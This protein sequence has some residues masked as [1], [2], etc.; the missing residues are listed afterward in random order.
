MK[1]PNV[2]QGR[3]EKVT[4]GWIHGVNSVRNPWNLPADQLKWGV[5]VTVRGGIVQTRPG[6]G[7]KLSLP[8]GNLQGGCFFASN[9][10]AK[11]AST[12]VSSGTTSTVSAT[13]YNYDGTTSFEEEL[14]Y[15]LFAVGG[16]VYFSPFP[17]V[18][19]KDWNDYKLTN[20]SLSPDVKEVV[21]CVATQT[22]SLSAGGDVTVT[23]SNR[24]VII[25][26]GVSAPA[27]WDG[28]DKR[29]GQESKIPV[30]YWMSFSGN[31]L[32]VAA[33]NIVFASDIGNPFSWIERTEG[34]GRGDFSFP[35][36]ITAMVDYIG[37]DNDT[38][39]IVFTDRSTYSLSSGI[40]DRS[41]WAST[42]NFQKTLYAT[43]GCVAGK[44][45]A[46][47]AGLMWW[48]S[49]GGLV[50]ANVASGAYVSSQSLYKDVE[51][52]RA[53]RYMPSNVS[54]ICATSFENY[55]LYSIPYLEA[56]PSATMVLDYAAAS[57]LNQSEVP[58]WAG[59]WNGTRPIEWVSGT[60]GQQ[61]RLFHFSVD[62]VPTNDG[63]YN[64]LWESFLP[65]RVDSYLQINP[66]GSTTTK[67]S[68][69]YGQAE[70]ALM[71]DGMDLK[72]IKYAEL[73]CS[74]IGGTVDLR[75]SYRGSK[76]AYQP[77]LN[78]RFLAVTDEYQFD[79]TPQAEKI[80]EYG[81]LRTQHRRV[82]TESVQRLDVSSCETRYSSDVDK[83]FSLLVEW[84][85]ELGLEAVR[86]FMDPWQE[87]SVGIP[88]SDEKESCII[89]EDGTST[90][91]ALEESPY[92]IANFNTQSW[93]ATETQ[94][95]TL[96]CTSGLG[97]DVSATA[98]ASAESFV[99]LADATQK[100]IT[101]AA[102]AASSAAQKY[103]QQN[104]C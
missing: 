39:L 22:A 99:S 57:E 14:P 89:H 2:T 4:A 58:A 38:K 16:S 53:K 78:T 100:A 71:G 43:I 33:R 61:P 97:F 62:Y 104:P 77:I 44:S 6:Q 29:G 21:F 72:Q 93:F 96:P 76:G 85:G 37:Q 68:R 24:V 10:Q 79:K 9:K 60:V 13:I 48:Y 50:N 73:D 83:A 41:L 92:E 87:I 35:R 80:A 55:L 91:I 65:E 51:M 74:Q 52:A 46:F 18:Q 56:L 95:I 101:L 42:A 54:S 31:R 103:R 98:T 32:W 67:Y 25:Q 12:S 3:I 40:L 1:S 17:L 88:Q 59:V 36:T 8:P 70:T 94:T 27:Y 5:N 64:H 69:I 19:P 90:L 82:S 47:Q 66:D 102:Q 11:A 15:I 30:G 84:C 34:A 63:S 45:V 81:I 86:V 26:D 49:R 23:P 7:M 20:I 75:V 28:S